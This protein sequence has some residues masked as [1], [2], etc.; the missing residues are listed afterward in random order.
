LEDDGDHNDAFPNDAVYGDET[1]IQSGAGVGSYNVTINISKW[2]S[3]ASEKV[4]IEVNDELST[5]ATISNTTF[6]KG[7][8]MLISGRISSLRGVIRENSTFDITFSSGTWEFSDTFETDSSGDFSYTY[9][10]S[11]ADP[12]RTWEITLSGNDSYGNKLNKTFTVEVVTPS[13]ILYYGVFFST[14]PLLIYTR[15]DEIPVSV[16]VRKGEQAIEDA[17]VSYKDP[18]GQ[19]RYLTEVT[20]GY[21]E[22]TYYVPM[23]A[24]TGSWTLAVQAIKYENSTLQAGASTYFNINIT[25]LEFV[26]DLIEPTRFVFTAGESIKFTISVKYGNGTPV[27][28]ASVRAETPS[29]DIL[30]FD[31]SEAHGYYTKTYTPSNTENG[32]WSLNVLATDSN[33][34]FAL[35][36]KEILIRESVPLIPPW[37]W[38][39]IAG[40][41]ISSALFWKIEGEVRF[42][43]WRFSKL[44]TESDRIE[45][46]K[47]I[48]EE[49]YFNRRIDEET[50]TKLMRD[51]EEQGVGVLSKL[52]AIQKK[53]NLKGKK[54]KTKGSKKK[55]SK[56]KKEKFEPKPL[57]E[58]EPPREL[59]PE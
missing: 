55:G 28:G 58:P 25:P 21:Y 26:Y 9:P 22:D 11:F 40:I 24:P 15:G 4:Q 59:P 14:N 54:P 38:I 48:V 46:M 29:G 20:P 34:N 44:K 1:I 53:A 30:I 3:V 8:N 31:E 52:A 5:T 27:T 50:Y 41:L 12:D 17:N 36:G 37:G 19:R 6:Y 13:Q 2:S 57:P 49:R 23:D 33:E 47:G 32:S 45:N 10:V 35:I 39:L 16:F 42:Y 51:Y 56:P 43:R 7:Y 18:A